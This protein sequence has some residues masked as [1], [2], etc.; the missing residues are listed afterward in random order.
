MQQ[1][2]IRCRNLLVF[3]CIICIIVLISLG[4]KG[5]GI[6]TNNISNGI[7]YGL[8]GFTI[9]MLGECAWF[10]NTLVN[11]VFYDHYDDLVNR[12]KLN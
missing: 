1:E 10:S 5:F 9:G 7:V 4:I 6:I 2:N 3:T 8:I 12:N 11:L